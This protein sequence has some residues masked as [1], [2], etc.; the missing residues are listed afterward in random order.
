MI[1]RD[2]YGNPFT[3]VNSCEICTNILYNYLPT[4]LIGEADASALRAL[5][6]RLDFTLEN[7]KETEAVLKQYEIKS[8]D[9]AGLT[10]TKGH[11]GRGVE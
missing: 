11:Y 10:Y 6:D 7:A 4:N 1:L 2:R 5:G 3:M 9:H 8:R